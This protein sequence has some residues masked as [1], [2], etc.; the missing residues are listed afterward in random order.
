ML[1]SDELSEI[2]DID[3]I[4]C[5]SPALDSDFSG[6]QSFRVTISFTHMDMGDPPSGSDF[7]WA[8]HI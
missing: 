2:V 1:I 7:T 5:G 3:T 8:P 4:D 6:W